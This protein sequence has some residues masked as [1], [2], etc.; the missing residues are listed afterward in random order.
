MSNEN[1]KPSK[2][3]QENFQML[4]VEKSS[5]F[6]LEKLIFMKQKAGFIP[7]LQNVNCDRYNE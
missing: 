4:E 3:N 6:P 7:R 1:H 5:D 2:H